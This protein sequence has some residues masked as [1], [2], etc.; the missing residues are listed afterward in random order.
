MVETRYKTPVRVFLLTV[1]FGSKTRGLCKVPAPLDKQS[2]ATRLPEP[3]NTSPS[4]VL[5]L[6]SMLG[7][8]ASSR[9]EF[10]KK[11]PMLNHSLIFLF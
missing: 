11:Q 1:S 10:G 8:N 9:E 5:S 3:R 4:A 6:G 2:L 7:Q